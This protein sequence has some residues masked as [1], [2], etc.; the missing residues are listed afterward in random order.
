MNTTFEEKT[1]LI[2]GATGLLGSHLVKRFLEFKNC[3][4]IA[5]GRNLTK[6][7]DVFDGCEG[8]GKLTLMEGD[9]SEGVPALEYDIDYIFHAASPIAGE[10]IRDYPVSVIRPNILGTINILEYLRH[11]KKMAGHEGCLVVF[12]SATVYSNTTDKDRCVS[13][14]E[15]S[16]ADNLDAAN[17]PYSESKRML[18]VIARSYHKQYGLN[19]KIARFSYLY[20][21]SKHAPNTAFYEFMNKTQRKEN[22]LLNSNG[23]PRRDNIYVDDAIEG[24]LCLCEKGISGESYNISSNGDKGN[25]AAIDEIAQVIASSANKNI[26]GNDMTVLFREKNTGRKQGLMLNNN[27]LKALGWNIQNSLEEGIEKTLKKYLSSNP[28]PKNE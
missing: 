2:T 28:V 12:S 20:G 15:T 21:Y 5:L 4:V 11:K 26:K 7:Q 19:V 23:A 18:E 3:R 14:E 22:L 8:V 27:K 16:V 17:A 6:L 9:V 24:L 25:F 10:T 1:I 13:E